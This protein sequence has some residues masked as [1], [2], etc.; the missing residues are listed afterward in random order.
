MKHLLITYLIVLLIASCKKD[1]TKK[2]FLYG[3]LIDN[4]N[5]IP[6]SNE[7]LYFYQNYTPAVNWL[8][9]DKQEALLE[10][11]KTDEN[12]NF[13]FSGKDYANKSTT[14]IYNSS[15]RLADGTKLVDGI[16]GEGDGINE[17]DS[18]IKNVGDIQKNGM[19]IDLDVKISSL[20][21]AV[22]YD[23]VIVYGLNEN[24]VILTNSIS[25]YFETTVTQ[26]LYTNN[27]W[28]QGDESYDKFHLITTMYFYSNGIVLKEIG[29][30]YFEPCL[31]SGVIIFEF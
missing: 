12:G 17:G 18:Y 11:I 28:I 30:N 3:R 22:S 31:T 26:T 15:I 9:Q 25:N 21:G 5:G 23:S 20:N 16:L 27:Y 1:P 7:P 19:T 4:C 14:G 6:V 10:E 29:Y 2:A 13:Y 8:E 24:G